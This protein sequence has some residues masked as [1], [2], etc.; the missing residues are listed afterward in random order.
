MSW[1]P[2]FRTQTL[3]STLMG[4]YSRFSPGRPD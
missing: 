3:T 1:M 4:K 2:I